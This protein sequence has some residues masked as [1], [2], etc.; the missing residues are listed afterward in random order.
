MDAQDLL[1]REVEIALL[2]GL[3]VL[4]VLVGGATMP[5]RGE[6][7]ESLWPLAGINAIPVVQ[8]SR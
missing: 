3:R 6:L 8:G 2:L 4:P 5:T 1:R 7:P